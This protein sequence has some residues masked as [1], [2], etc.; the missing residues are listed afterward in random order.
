MR[1]PMSVIQNLKTNKKK[2]ANKAKKQPSLP[3]PALSFFKYS[4]LFAVLFVALAAWA[5]LNRS[6]AEEYLKLNKRL[7]AMGKEER[8][9][10]D[11]IQSLE[12]RFD[13]LSSSSFE[14]ERIS[15]ENHLMMKPNEKVIVFTEKDSSRR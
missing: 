9:L 4:M 6:T 2:R 14:I 3:N 11:Q 1:M 5:I 15:R 8:A 13:I 10:E 7:K 12:E